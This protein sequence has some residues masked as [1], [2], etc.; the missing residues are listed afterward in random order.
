MKFLTDITEEHIETIR[1]CMNDVQNEYAPD[2]FLQLR[3]NSIS[4]T[5]SENPSL[6]QF[7][8]EDLDIICMCM[9][10]ALELL[11]TVKSELEPGDLLECQR[12]SEEVGDILALLQ[13]Q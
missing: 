2:R 10:D 12:F 13:K 9:H 5:L 4:Q 8:S 3:V 6:Y 11:D 7:N 1:T